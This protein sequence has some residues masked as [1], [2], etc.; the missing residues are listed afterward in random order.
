MCR[1][2]YAVIAGVFSAGHYACCILVVTNSEF[3]RWRLPGRTKTLFRKLSRYFVKKHIFQKYAFFL[4]GVLNNLHAVSMCIVET[5]IWNPKI[6][7]W[8]ANMLIFETYCRASTSSFS[9]APRLRL[10]DQEFRVGAEYFLYQSVQPGSGSYT[11]FCQIGLCKA[12]KQTAKLIAVKCIVARLR[13]RGMVFSS[14][15]VTAQHF[16]PMERNVNFKHYV[17]CG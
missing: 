11:M 17:G 9:M 8:T 13:I 10:D 14:R 4:G 15:Q 2:K 7:N 6:C 16:T 3:V 1:Q 5:K 12:T